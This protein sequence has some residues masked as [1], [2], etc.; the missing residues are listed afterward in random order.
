MSVFQPLDIT[1]TLDEADPEEWMI[2][3]AGILKSVHFAGGMRYDTPVAR[4]DGMFA[5]NLFPRAGKLEL[6]AMIPRLYAGRFRS[7]PKSVCSQARTVELSS[8]SPFALE[9]DGEVYRTTAARLSV[10]PRVLRW[11]G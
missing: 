8:P 2:S 1:L 9:L 10:V 11:C 5:V 3:S 7:H 6:L 4:D